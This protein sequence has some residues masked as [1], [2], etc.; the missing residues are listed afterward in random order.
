LRV[1]SVTTLVDPGGN[2]DW[3]PDDALLLYSSNSDGQSKRGYDIYALNIANGQA[4]R[5]TH[6]AQGW[7]EHAHFSPAGK[8]IVW[9]SSM[10]AGSTAELLKTELWDMSP[11]GSEQTQLTFFNTPD[12]FMYSG[13]R[14]SVIPADLA[15]SPDG[16]QFALLVI[17][18]QSQQT[19]YSMPGRIVLVKLK[20]AKAAHPG[21]ARL[22]AGDDIH[23]DDQSERQGFTVGQAPTHSLAAVYRRAG[24]GHERL[25]L[26]HHG[27]EFR[28][29]SASIARVPEAGFAILTLSNGVL[30]WPISKN[31][32][33]GVLNCCS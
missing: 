21:S 15:W 29:F 33:F 32:I 26:Y 14:Y 23:R 3:S 31:L 6:T 7:D 1:D 10:N 9:A 30:D 8:C 16:T 18:N 4:T 27:G 12:S 28:G 17:V 19:E 5:L 22:T 24:P 11:D 20:L 13:D 25:A 2:V